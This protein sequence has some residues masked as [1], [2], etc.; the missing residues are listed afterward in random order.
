MSVQ[1]HFLWVKYLFRRKINNLTSN[2]FNV[3]IELLDH[4]YLDF[5]PAS[6]IFVLSVPNVKQ[7]DLNSF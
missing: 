4:S 6:F 1:F 2:K 7:T 3:N 5:P